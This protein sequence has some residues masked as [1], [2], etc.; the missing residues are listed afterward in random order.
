MAAQVANVLQATD[1][2]VVFLRCWSIGFDSTSEG[3]VRFLSARAGAGR[4]TTGSLTT[5]QCAKSQ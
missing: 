1:R 3:V 4:T 5:K 2:S